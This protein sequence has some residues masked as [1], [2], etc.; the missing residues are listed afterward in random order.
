MVAGKPEVR[1]YCYRYILND[2]EIGLPSGE[3]VVT[4]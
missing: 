2:V 3:V 4:A 1:R